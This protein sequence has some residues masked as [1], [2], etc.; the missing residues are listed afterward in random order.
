MK[1]TYK[2]QF[3]T[4]KSANIC[5]VQETATQMTQQIKFLLRCHLDNFTKRK[6]ENFLQRI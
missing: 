4:Q 2:L 1:F 3:L 5:N 6:E